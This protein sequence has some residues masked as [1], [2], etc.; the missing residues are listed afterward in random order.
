MLKLQLL[1]HSLQYICFYLKIIA[2][3]GQIFRF[4]FFILEIVCQASSPYMSL[5]A[6]P[7]QSGLGNSA[8]LSCCLPGGGVWILTL[9]LTWRKNGTE[10]STVFSDCPVSSCTSPTYTRQAWQP[11]ILPNCGSTW[12]SCD[13]RIV[14]LPLE[15]V[16]SW[17]QESL[18]ALTISGERLHRIQR[19]I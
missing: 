15:F 18:C 9:F 16:F 10:C 8:L 5:F 1:V 2:F 13:L 3:L 17:P 4:A 19:V 6:P 11:S 14:M 7:P 12:A